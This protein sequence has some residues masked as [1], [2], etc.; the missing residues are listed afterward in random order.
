MPGPDA[1]RVAS[2]VIRGT[3]DDARPRRRAVAA[4]G[5]REGRRV[6]RVPAAAPVHL[7]FEPVDREILG[8]EL[9]EAQLDL[10]A[11]RLARREAGGIARIERDRGEVHRIPSDTRL[12]FP[13]SYTHLRAHET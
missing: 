11:E 8:P 6:A 4:L 9:S 13:V 3:R 2:P 1:H 10:D 5:E 7:A 12:R